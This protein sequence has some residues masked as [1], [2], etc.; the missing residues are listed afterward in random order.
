VANDPAGSAGAGVALDE[1]VVVVDVEFAEERLARDV[2]TAHVRHRP[3]E[4]WTAVADAVLDVEEREA[5]G[6]VP[7]I[8]VRLETRE[9]GL[10]DIGPEDVE[11]RGGR[12]SRPLRRRNHAD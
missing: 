1:E 2:A 3:A 12:P 5:P 9:S 4:R 6:P 8:F 10:P 7:G 11:R